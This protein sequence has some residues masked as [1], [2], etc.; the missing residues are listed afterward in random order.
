MPDPNEILTSS[1]EPSPPVFFFFF[2]FPFFFPF[3][4][5]FIL[6]KFHQFHPLSK[7]LNN[8]PPYLCQI[9]S[10][11][12]SS[13]YLHSIHNPIQKK[14]YL[15]HYW[16][17][18]VYVIAVLF[19]WGNA[20]RSLTRSQIPDYHNQIPGSHLFPGVS[21]PC[22]RASPPRLSATLSSQTIC[23]SHTPSPWR[24]GGGG[25]W[26]ILTVYSSSQENVNA[27]PEDSFCF[28]RLLFPPFALLL[29]S[30]RKWAKINL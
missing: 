4:I 15:Y 27:S 17:R 30:S 22:P 9:L 5:S 23:I 29:F 13:T 19:W 25:N 10:I 12:I 8:K 2:F 28:F 7:Q 14:P 3:W 18:L 16:D 1:Q 21:A 26:H 6:A 20:A 24:R 11:S